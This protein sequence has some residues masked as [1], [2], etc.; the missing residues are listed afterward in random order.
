MKSMFE[1][2]HNGHDSNSSDSDS[3][4]ESWRRGRNSVELIHVLASTG[5]SPSDSDIE[6]GNNDL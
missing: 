2:Q 1:K 5:I 3:E 6:I 4:A